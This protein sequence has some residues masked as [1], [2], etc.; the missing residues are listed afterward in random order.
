MYLYVKCLRSL[1]T[2]THFRSTL[3]SSIASVLQVE[4]LD[5]YQVK[6][7]AVQSCPVYTVRATA[8][9]PDQNAQYVHSRPRHKYGSHTASLAPVSPDQS[10]LVRASK[11]LVLVTVL[12]PLLSRLAVWHF[13]KHSS[14]CLQAGKFLFS[15][16]NAWPTPNENVKTYIGGGWTHSSHHETETE[17]C[18]FF[19]GYAFRPRAGNK[20]R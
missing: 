1:S 4:D 10:G 12:V 6:K 14:T 18:S 2:E 3:H 13:D 7:L 5:R 15:S 11:R 9:S 16:R 19:L 17:L 20:F 8:N